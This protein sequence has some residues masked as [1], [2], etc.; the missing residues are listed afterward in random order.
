MKSI[1]RNVVIVKPRE[2][3]LAWLQ[4]LP[5]PP[6]NLTLDELRR[7]SLCLLISE[8]DSQEEAT[9][10][11]SKRYKKIFESELMAWHT[12][13]RDW[14]KNRTLAMFREWFDLEFHSEVV[15]FVDMPIEKEDFYLT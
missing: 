7:D 2:P 6:E 12:V 9:A 4:R 10:L 8:S 11:I 1:N 14:P 13:K 3:F 5:R 15:D